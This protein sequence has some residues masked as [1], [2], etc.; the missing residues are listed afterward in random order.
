MEKHFSVKLVHIITSSKSFNGK[1]A[2][3]I[4]ERYDTVTKKNKLLAVSG[5]EILP[6]GRYRKDVSKRNIG[7]DY[8]YF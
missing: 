1:F 5:C 6:D 2:S 8:L 3:I 4:L 7:L